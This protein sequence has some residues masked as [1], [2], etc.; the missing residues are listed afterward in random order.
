VLPGV[1]ASLGRSLEY[2]SAKLYEQL[3]LIRLLLETVVWVFIGATTPRLNNSYVVLD[4]K[5]LPH[6]GSHR[7]AMLRPRH[8]RT[9]PI[10][11]SDWEG[12]WRGR[13]VK[14]GEDGGG[15]GGRGWRSG[16]PAVY[17]G[18]WR[19]RCGVEVRLGFWVLIG[20]SG[21]EEL[22]AYL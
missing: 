12:W 22:R 21:G 1:Y 5:T 3:L 10:G 15:A 16:A 6:D 14:E 17:Y 8:A 20:G 9:T 7:R 4:T 11:E 18:Q 2:Q 13:A 19:W